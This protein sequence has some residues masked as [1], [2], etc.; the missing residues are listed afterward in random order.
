MRTE[1]SRLVLIPVPTPGLNPELWWGNWCKIGIQSTNNQ[2][3]TV[4]IWLFNRKCICKLIF[5]K[6]SYSCSP[7]LD[8]QYIPKYLKVC[9]SKERF[10]WKNNGQRDI[11]AGCGSSGGQESRTGSGQLLEDSVNPFADSQLP[12]MPFPKTAPKRN[13][14]FLVLLFH[15]AFHTYSSLILLTCFSH[16]TGHAFP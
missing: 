8:V 7:N 3:V 5:R 6:D 1:S 11:L 4:C 13:C 10:P 12:H 9:L 2:R 14:I 15:L 16:S